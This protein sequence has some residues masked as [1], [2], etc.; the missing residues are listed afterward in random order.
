MGMIGRWIDEKCAAEP[1]VMRHV[2]NRKFGN[3]ESFLDGDGCGCLVG[4]YA[5]ASNARWAANYAPDPDSEDFQVGVRVSEL[6]DF[7]GDTW[8]DNCRKR[9]DAFVVRLLKQRI[10]KALGSLMLKDDISPEQTENNTVFQSAGSRWA[11]NEQPLASR[12]AQSRRQ[13][14][15]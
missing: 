12:N 8:R 9:S 11:R 6:T 5:L 15:V 3:L 2:L 1:E 4:S 14:G 7:C 10:R 13:T